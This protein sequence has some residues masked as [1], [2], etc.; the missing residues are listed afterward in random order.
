M[1]MLEAYD[2]TGCAHSAAQTARLFVIPT[3]G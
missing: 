3:S 1:E 2:V